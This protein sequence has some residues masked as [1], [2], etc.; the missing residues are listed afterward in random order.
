MSENK[1]RKAPETDRELLDAFLTAM[2]EVAPDT[3]EEIDDFLEERGY[4][5]QALN[6]RSERLL[7][8]LLE[9]SPLNPLNRAKQERE[10]SAK[11]R[12][13][14]IS[15]RRFTRQQNL[16]FFQ[17]TQTRLGMAAH[18]RNADLDSMSDAELQSMRDDLESLQEDSE[19]KP[20]MN[21]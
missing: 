12:N 6:E 14:R 20:A 3:E 10:E 5:L 13:Q 1:N 4:D 17:A 8:P 15:A 19:N 16:A 9:A 21:K 7:K 2:G 11:K 18:F